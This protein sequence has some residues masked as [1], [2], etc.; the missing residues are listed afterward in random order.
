MT[1]WMDFWPAIQT[2]IFGGKNLNIR[3]WVQAFRPNSSNIP[4]SQPTLT[5]NISYHFQWP[6]PWHGIKRSMESNGFIIY[7]TSQLMKMKSDVVLKQSKLNILILLLSKIIESKEIVAVHWQSQK[8]V[9][10]TCIGL[11]INL[12]QTRYDDR[13]YWTLHSKLV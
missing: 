6:W 10:F 7:H 2:A 11:R 8:T 12:V 3:H 1:S 4:C 9:T 13:Y 5:S